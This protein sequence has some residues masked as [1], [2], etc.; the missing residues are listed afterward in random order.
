MTNEN[1]PVIQYYPVLSSYEKYFFLYLAVSFLIELDK[2]R[3]I[4][5]QTND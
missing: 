5:F 4:S 2:T 1:Y 3:T